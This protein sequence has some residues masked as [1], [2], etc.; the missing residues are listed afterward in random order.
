MKCNLSNYLKIPIAILVTC[1]ILAN[2]KILQKQG[3]TSTSSSLFPSLLPQRGRHTPLFLSP[4]PR[5]TSQRES[6]HHL[7]HNVASSSVRLAIG[8]HHQGWRIWSRPRDHLP[9]SVST[10]ASHLPL[11]FLYVSPSPCLHGVA[12]APPGHRRPLLAAASPKHHRQRPPS[13]TPSMSYRFG[14]NPAPKPYPAPLP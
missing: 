8:I 6:C 14:E 3:V 9:L 10:T 7:L 12:G 1:I 11:H 2:F 5:D 4:R 13:A